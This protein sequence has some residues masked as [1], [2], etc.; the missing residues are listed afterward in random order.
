MG[1]LDS[2]KS[3]GRMVVPDPVTARRVGL[4]NVM[5]GTILVVTCTLPTGAMA[6]FSPT[7]SRVGQRIYKP[8]LVSMGKNLK[9]EIDQIAQKEA[10]ETNPA[11]K[12]ALGRQ[13]KSLEATLPSMQISPTMG[14]EALEDS[15][16]RYV[17]VFDMLAML[18]LN[19][20][21]VIAGVGLLGLRS[22]GR[23]FAITVTLVKLAYLA[24]YTA[25]SVVWLVP[26][27]LKQMGAQLEAQRR[28]AGP[29]GSPFVMSQS[30]VAASSYS[31]VFLMAAVAG[32]YGLVILFLLLKPSVRVACV[33]GKP[34]LDLS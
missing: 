10:K 18:A 3:Q 16:I 28:A 26:V 23:R 7:I 20:A 9:K 13:R 2:S 29:A 21:M 33:V 8:V 5:I 19:S 15:R 32:L 6:I 1:D 12:A 25:L 14:F 31:V 34:E 4:V 17:A 24:A 30:F 11:T 22:W 27:Q